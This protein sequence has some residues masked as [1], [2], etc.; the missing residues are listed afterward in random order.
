MG[1]MY[2]VSTP[3]GNLEDI[4]LRALRILAEVDFIA[5]EDTKKT[6]M[7]L[8]NLKIERKAKFISY[9]EENE[10]RRIP[11]IMNFLKE[12]KNVALVCNAGTPIISD[13]GFKL[14]RECIKTGIEVAPIPGA[15]AVL[16]ALV[17]SGLPTDKFLFLGYLPKK[18]GKRKKMLNNLATVLH[19]IVATVII[20]ESPYRILKTLDDLKDIFGEIEIVICRELTKVYEEKI[21]GRVSD[22]I[23]HFEKRKPKGEMTVVFH[24]LN[25]KPF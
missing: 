5:C 13:P 24:L 7:L 6:G 8:K 11:E 17:C 18:I 20:Y 2:V 1:K 23:R 16:V 12:G 22:V 10:S 25:N 3:V 19:N 15:S 4:T 14:I 9:Y 21:R